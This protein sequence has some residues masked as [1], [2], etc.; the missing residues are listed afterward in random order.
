MSDHLF[1]VHMTI[2]K[3]IVQHVPQGHNVYYNK[4]MGDSRNAADV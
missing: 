4:H 3:Y 2:S 1:I